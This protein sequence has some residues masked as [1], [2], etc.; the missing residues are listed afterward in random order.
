MFQELLAQ[1]NHGYMY[2]EKMTI[3]MQEKN[4]ILIADCLIISECVYLDD[5]VP[6][7]ITRMPV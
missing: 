3:W 6:V 5:T 1:N 4:T 7:V 2:N